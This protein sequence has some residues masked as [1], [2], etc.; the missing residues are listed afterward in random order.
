MIPSKSDLW[1]SLRTFIASMM[2]L[3]IAL[4]LSLANP[5][6][7]MGTVYIVSQPL[8]G[9]MRSKTFYRI[10]GTLTGAAGALVLVGVFG[11][12]PVLLLLAIAVWSGMFL[13]FSMLDRTPRTYMFRLPAYTLPLIAFPAM[14]APQLVF[15]IALARTEEILV[16]IVCANLVAGLALVQRAGPVIRK[17]LAQW[18][19]QAALLAQ[20]L[21]AGGTASTNRHQLATELAALEQLTTHLGFDNPQRH[22]V[23]VMV[24]LRARMRRLLPLLSSLDAIRQ[25]LHRQDTLDPALQG[26]FSA[27]SEHLSGAS[28]SDGRVISSLAA[29]KQRWSDLL[30]WTAHRRLASFHLLADDCRHLRERLADT[31]LPEQALAYPHERLGGVSHHLDHGLVLFYASAVS[32]GM[33]LSGLVWLISGWTAGA[34]AMVLGTVACALFCAL[35]EPAPRMMRFLGVNL[36]SSLL[37]GLLLFAVLPQVETFEALV[38]CFFLPCLVFGVLILR[39]QFST[40]AMLMIVFTGSTVGLHGAYQA[41]FAA[42]LEGCLASISGA[43]VALLWT[44]LIRPFGRD[45]TLARL[46][47]AT[48]QELARLALRGDQD[49][50]RS[51][52]RLHDRQELSWPRQ[53]A[54][55]GL[56][57]VRL[58]LALL[59][60][61]RQL[62]LLDRATRQ[63]IERLLDALGQHLL[64]CAQTGAFAAADSHQLTL[65][66]EA[67]RQVLRG[68][69]SSMQ[70]TCS[71]LVELR[72]TCH[73]DAPAPDLL[74]APV[75]AG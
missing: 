70:D 31:D 44:M 68:A 69:D 35:D 4:D 29:S 58:G 64:A 28:K 39:P 27:L 37:G 33:F 36:A 26:H 25:A 43:L 74:G 23:S 71:A 10:G 73:P 11:S 6:W 22:A 42:F 12:T 21:M 55:D 60:L 16:G 9:A 41:D 54:R 17:R 65:L 48:Y 75:H 46:R 57:E 45:L 47:R 14:Q 63:P 40:E 34:N 2:A 52:A 13:F 8:L 50:A 30:A 24:Q 15:D 18:F 72:I 66:D 61:R 20:E 19:A 53:P 62:P 3:Y 5:I 56:V 59:H 49:L 38:A 1:F 67:L 7:A 32:L 51:I